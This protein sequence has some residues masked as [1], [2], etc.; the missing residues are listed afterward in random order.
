MKVKDESGNIT[1]IKQKTVKKIKNLKLVS[2]NYIII[3]NLKKDI[4]DTMRDVAVQST[5]VYFILPR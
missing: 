4:G 5:M 2:D 3:P 1:K